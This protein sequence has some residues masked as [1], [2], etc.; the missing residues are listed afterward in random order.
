[1]VQLLF[2]RVVA[3][4]HWLKQ[5]L[6]SLI[7]RQ[8]NN[9]RYRYPGPKQAIPFSEAIAESSVTVLWEGAAPPTQ[10]LTHPYPFLNVGEIVFTPPYVLSIAHGRVVGKRG[11]VI[12]PAGT[13]FTDISPE[14]PRREHD[15]FL[16][17]QGRTSQP[18]LVAGTV[19]VLNCGA[20]S[21]YFH[22]LFDTIARLRFLQQ[23]EVPIDYYCVA[24]HQPFQ[25]ALVRLFKIDPSRIIVLKKNT[26]LEAH[27]LIA[28]ALPGHHQ[29][30]AQVHLKDA[31]TYRFV[32]E[33]VLAQID[34]KS[35]SYAKRVYVQRKARRVI[36][37]EKALLQALSV[38]G[39]WQVL[40]LEEH[41]ALE[42][43]AIFYHAEEVVALHGAGLA[44]TV[45]CQP[46]THIVEIFSPVLLEPI[47]YQIAQQFDLR[48]S[49]IIVQDSQTWRTRDG[50]LNEI[51][52]I[53]L[54]AVIQ[55]L[56]SH[57]IKTM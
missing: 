56:Q 40:R 37:N 45:Y 39:D 1:M 26:H 17:N 38:L 32:R 6:P 10:T 51:V 52:T 29:D 25:K 11:D 16:L 23:L 9:L 12:T 57:Q 46:G 8:Y 3:L 34:R 43:A 55:Q 4:R 20:H 49:P 41:T 14:I 7:W 27:Q 53:D 22:F 33:T 21:N 5:Q 42:Q 48:Y 54:P 44:N 15:H 2:K 36:A 19:A 31:A 28:T 50:H 18:T 13:I 24:Q 35:Q 47:Y 30:H